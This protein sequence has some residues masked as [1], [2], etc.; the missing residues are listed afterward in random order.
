[1][2]DKLFQELM[3]SVKQGGAI[4]RGDAKPSRVFNFENPDVKAIREKYGLSQN[5][6]AKLLG[7]SASTLRN[8]EQGRRN[9]E[10]PARIL[11][12][13]AD[14]HPEAILDSVYQ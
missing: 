2:N 6:F 10:G 8:W 5:K 1:M 11:L 13:I 9:P 3:D 4:L 7:I 12:S 14:K